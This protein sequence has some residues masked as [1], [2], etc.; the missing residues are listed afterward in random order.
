MTDILT[1]QV[2][3]IA[4]TTAVVVAS[5]FVLSRYLQGRQR[6]MSPTA[7]DAELLARLERIEQVVESTA[8]EVERISEANRFMAKLLSERAAVPIPAAPPG[9]TTTPH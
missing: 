8:V 1:I 9:R 6:Q 2:T 5:L 7:P 4:A 3:T